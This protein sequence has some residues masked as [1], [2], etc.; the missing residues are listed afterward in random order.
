MVVNE[1]RRPKINDFDLTLGI[2]L[3]Q[4]ILRFQITMDQIEIVNEVKSI[5]DLLRHFLKSWH[6][7]VM[8]FFDFSIVL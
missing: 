6:V 8:L 3:D 2:R 5:Q 1:A 4:N 7:E